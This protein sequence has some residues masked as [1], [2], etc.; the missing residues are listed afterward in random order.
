MDLNQ[1]FLGFLDPTGSDWIDMYF[2]VDL[3]TELDIVD[4]KKGKKEKKKKNRR[5]I[6]NRLRQFAR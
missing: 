4:T 5:E 2:G 1:V 6:R 3:G